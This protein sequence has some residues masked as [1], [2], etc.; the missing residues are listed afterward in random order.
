MR[1]ALRIGSA[2]GILFALSASSGCSTPHRLLIE[3]DPQGAIIHVDGEYIGSAPCV[4]EIEDT[5]LYPDITIEAELRNSE[6]RRRTL[7]RNRQGLFPE[8]V[9]FTLNDLEVKVSSQLG[10]FVT[11]PAPVAGGTTV[12]YGPG[13]GPSYNNNSQPSVLR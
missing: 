1:K 8:R 9:F 13:P 4:F 3:A 7:T 2:L 11:P 5:A 6:R 12:I 10:P